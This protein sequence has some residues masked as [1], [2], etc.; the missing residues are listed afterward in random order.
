MKQ[1][2]TVARELMDVAEGIAAA[3]AELAAGRMPNMVGLEK[4]AAQACEA[5]KNLPK[6]AQQE[7]LVLLQDLVILL[8][9]CE[10]DLRAFHATYLQKTGASDDR[11]S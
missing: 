8:N 4:R 2:D 5:I 11:Q 10:R 7:N 3:R 1:S 6:A 9:E